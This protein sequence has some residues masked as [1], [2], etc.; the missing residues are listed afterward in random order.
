[1]YGRQGASHLDIRKG[2]GGGGIGRNRFGGVKFSFICGSE[3]GGDLGYDPNERGVF[4]TVGGW[5]A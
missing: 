3:R 5:F 2:T 1:V 4:A